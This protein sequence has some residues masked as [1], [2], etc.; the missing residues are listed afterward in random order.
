MVGNPVKT[1]V[2][3]A[4]FIR[5]TIVMVYGQMTP[6]PDS[7]GYMSLGLR[8]L[9]LDLSGYEGERSPGYPFLLALC[10]LPFISSHGII[11]LGILLPQLIMGI[12]ALVLLYK[13]CLLLGKEKGLAL[14]VTLIFT[15]YIPAVFFEMAVLTE[16]L[17][18]FVISLI[19]Y[20]FFQEIAGD[21]NRLVWLVILCSYLVLIKPFYIFLPFV[22]LAIFL[23]KK[24]SLKYILIFIFP[25]LAFLGWSYVNKINTGYF[26][27]TTFYGFNLAQ[28]C[29]SFAENTTPEFQ[30]I[31]DIYAKYRDNRTT[32]KEE[33]MAIWEAYP[34]LTEN[35]GLSFPDLSKKLYDYSIATIK[36]NPGSYLGQVFISW[37]DFWKTSLYWEP[38][39]FA[40]PEAGQPVLYIT[41]AERILFQLIKILFVLL[42]PYNI[43]RGIRKRKVEPP[44]IISLVVLTASLLQAFVTYG[45]NSRF[46]FPF[47]SLILISVVLNLIMYRKKKATQ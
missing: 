7:E 31:G 34:E 24:R 17:S 25:L 2:I 16:T 26:V 43:I 28:N 36:K 6:Y 8:F 41:Y 44:F 37:C 1:I 33:S 19:F 23:L 3:T 42:I 29:V 10:S 32:D 9:N 38:H 13:I 27:S 47:E 22:L 5:I 20:F 46:S 39:N 30:Q 45:T 18:L 35:T 14:A 11:P 4:V 40:V 15:A 21:R 12:V